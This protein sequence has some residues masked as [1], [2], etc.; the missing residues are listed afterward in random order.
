MSDEARNAKIAALIRAECEREK[1]ARAEAKRNLLLT[2][3]DERRE[4]DQEE[5][6]DTIE[7]EML[8]LQRKINDRIDD[9]Y[10]DLKSSI[11]LSQIIHPC[12]A[13]VLA[14]TISL[15]AA[16]IWA[17]T[18]TIGSPESFAALLKNATTPVELHPMMAL[19]NATQLEMHIMSEVM[20]K[21]YNEFFS[22]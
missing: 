9:R 2:Q 11:N 14:L 21:F 20:T 19:Q 15:L 7:G 6:T 16:A 13:I 5:I 10:Y 12:P 8:T 3:L 17:F 4:K 22:F 1:A 18:N